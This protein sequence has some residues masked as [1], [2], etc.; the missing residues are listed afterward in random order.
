[1]HTIKF[2]AQHTGLS[3]HTIRAWE[4]RYAALSPERTATNRRLYTV[5]DVQKLRLLQKAVQEGH[6]IGQIA[7][8]PITSLQLLVS[9]SKSAVEAAAS[10]LDPGKTGNAPVFLD[11]CMNAVERLDAEAL[12]V[13]L[14]R[15]AA[16]LGAMPAIEHVILPMLTRIGESWRE[17]GI[18]PAQEHMATAVVRTFLGRTLSDFEPNMHAPLLV[19]TTPVGQL[20]E[21]GALIAGVTAA[22]E[23]WRVLYLGPNLPAEEIAGAALQSGAKAIALSI[24][25]PPDDSRIWQELA[26]LRKFT[27]EGLAI[28]AGGRASEVYSVRLAS[29]GASHILDLQ[30][31]R[32]E[33]EALR[34]R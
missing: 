7:A 6:S 17:G 9:E 1:M 27:G 19:V 29:I 12:D 16:L 23:G 5:E 18:R 22:S 26:S 14:S 3:Q 33:L 11:D 10:P 4:R 13:S 2:V 28:F 32:L 20:H 15:A 21:L 25:H 24:V 30:G 8:L 31:L 34:S